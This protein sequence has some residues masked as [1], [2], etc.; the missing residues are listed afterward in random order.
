MSL[1]TGAHDVVIW[2]DASNVYECH[3]WEPMQIAWSPG[4]KWLHPAL[5]DK[6]GRLLDDDRDDDDDDDDNVQEGW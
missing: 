1:S 5:I 6:A 2:S 3:L 4:W